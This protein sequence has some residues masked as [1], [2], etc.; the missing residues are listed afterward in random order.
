M[1]KLVIILTVSVISILFC[2]Q[3][4]FS[5]TG[6]TKNPN[7]LLYKI[8]RL[9]E[10]TV[11]PKT[12]NLVALEMRYSAKVRGIDT[13]LFD[14]KVQ[15]NGSP[16]R[17]QLPQSDF[18][19]D[20]YE[21]IR[22]LCPGDSGVFLINADSLFLRT[23][24]L[25]E[26]PAALDSESMLTFY[27]HLLTADSPEMLA[28]AEEK[29]LKQYCEKNRITDAPAASGIYVLVSDPGA[30]RKIDSGCIVTLHFAVSFIDGNQIFS[31]K[32]SNQP[33]QFIY[34]EKFDTQG[35]EEALGKMKKGNKSKVIVPSKMAF[36]EMGKGNIVPPYTTII[37]DVEIV[38]VQTRAEYE[39]EQNEK[40][41]AA[42]KN[43][44]RLS[45]KYL[46]DN[47]ITVKPTVSGL[48]YIE[49]IAG[50][51]ARAVA[52]KLVKVHYTGT[53]LDGKKFDSSRDRNQPLEFTLGKGQ[54]I[55]GLEEG[56]AMMKAGGRAILIMPSTLGY[57]EI[58]KGQIPRFSTLVFD[59]ELL[60]VQ[61]AK[62]VQI[63]GKTH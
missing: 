32:N 33:L 7:G 62:P 56:I 16:V 30:G 42:R 17:F 34:G 57:G 22:M 15:F 59:I 4:C 8:Y 21:A 5:Q 19:G 43:E 48:Y 46:K 1:N 39:L 29:K 18:Q 24:K 35:L 36:G 31:S 12:G 28:R 13:L 20:L 2:F 63:N 60:D 52:G 23:F 38:N 54:M 37:Y 9:N 49:K 40:R 11:K 53:L 44:T 6:F 55:K 45:D 50:K 51:G 25:N 47:K 58:D 14:S 3:Y 27:M 26:R 41:E 61:D 10:D